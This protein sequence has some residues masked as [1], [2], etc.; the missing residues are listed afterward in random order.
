MSSGLP[1]VVC[2]ACQVE[3]GLEAILGSDDARGVVALLARMPGSPSLRKALLRY[4][5]LF[6]P[7]KRQIGWDRVEKLLGEVVEMMESG[8]VTRAGASY[9][10]PLD[11]WQAA[12]DALFAMPTLRRPLK[13]H[14][15][16]LEIL[17]GLAGKADA[18]A[19]QQRIASGRGET[20]VAQASRLPTAKDAGKDACA[21]KPRT[22]SGTAAGLQSLRD[23]LAGNP[24]S[25]QG[26]NHGS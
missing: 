17:V 10:T 3:M 18:R 23:V 19:E 16:L 20:P 9:A 26:E 11:Y 21:T 4:V 1:R 24:L 8:R 22:R 12:L 6:A 2:P 25:T 5:G 7:A 14:G 15:L 13:S